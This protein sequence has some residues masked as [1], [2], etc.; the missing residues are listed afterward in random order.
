MD[1][2]P[3]KEV[4]MVDI[5]DDIKFQIV[6]AY[7]NNLKG[8]LKSIDTCEREIERLKVQAT[9]LKSMSLGDKVQSN[10]DVHKLE[11]IT[12][13]IIEYRKIATAEAEIF[14]QEYIVART[15]M[16]KLPANQANALIRHYLLGDT[17]EQVC[18]SLNYSYS[19]IMQI[20]EDGII[21]LYDLLPY[22][23]REEWRQRVIPR[24]I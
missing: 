18:V 5:D 6:D 21:A 24:S 12:H 2:L 4:D 8:M 13:N 9:G 16:R 11:T 14:F 20:R 3:A 15:A 1:I 17:W 7:V 10:S 19:R 23:V 22:S